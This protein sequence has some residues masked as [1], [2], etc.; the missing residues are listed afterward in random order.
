MSNGLIVLR[1]FHPIKNYTITAKVD[2]EMFQ[3]TK[4]RN[5]DIFLDENIIK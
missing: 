3:V 5:S 4:E 2:R 1:F